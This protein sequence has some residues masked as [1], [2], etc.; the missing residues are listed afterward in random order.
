MS[1]ILTVLRVLSVAAL[2]SFG[3]S[4]AASDR[5]TLQIGANNSTADSVFI[6]GHIVDEPPP[7]LRSSF[8]GAGIR[9]GA[10][11]RVYQW[12][13]MDVGW[14]KFGSEDRY[15]SYFGTVL[16]P[17]PDFDCG[18]DPGFVVDNVEQSGSGFWVAAAPTFHSGPWQFIG[19][20]GVSRT[21]IESREASDRSNRIESSETAVMFGFGAGYYFTERLGVRL[22]FEQLGDEARQVG[23]SMSVRF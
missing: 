13:N 4:V 21:T 14:A 18:G 22:D 19:K 11:V 16:C 2:A 8:S 12:L 20:L 1:K 3:S 7:S 6:G 17:G 15:T 5:F 23:L 10:T 9:L